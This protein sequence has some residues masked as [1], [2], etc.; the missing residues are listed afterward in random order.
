MKAIWEAACSSNKG[1]IREVNEDNFYFDGILRKKESE[2]LE[3]TFSSREEFPGNLFAVFDGLS[4]EEGAETAS[5]AAADSLLKETC[6]IEKEG[7]SDGPPETFLEKAALHMNHAICEAARSG[8]Q[9]MGSTAVMICFFQ[10]TATVCNVGD[11]RAYYLHENELVQLSEDHT[12]AGFMAE[13]KISGRKP[14]L[15]QYLGIAPEEMLIEPYLKTIRWCE[16]DQYLLCSDGLTDMLSENEIADILREK[17]PAVQCVSRLMEAALLRGGKDNITV[18]LIRNRRK[19]KN[20]CQDR[21]VSSGKG[22]YVR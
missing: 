5:C 17:R 22:M 12:D 11:S 2:I 18:I 19:H 21:Q 13:R 8:F 6:L 4:G 7:V 20:D 10:E 3:S 9:K 15:R 16:E 1:R 14:R